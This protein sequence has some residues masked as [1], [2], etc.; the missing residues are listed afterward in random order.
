MRAI[1]IV[2]L[3]LALSTA[4]ASTSQFSPFYPALVR[5]EQIDAKLPYILREKR[6][7]TCPSNYNDCSNLGAPS[8]CCIS[9][10]DC[11]LDAARHVACCPKGS[12]CTGAINVGTQLASTTGGVVVVGTP[13]S[14]GGFIFPA[15]TTVQTSM[16]VTVAAAITTP[17]PISNQ[18]Y[19]FPAI[20]TSFANAA[21]C[22][23]AWSGCQNEYRKCT[24]QLAGRTDG[25]TISA[26]S[27]GITIVGAS[28]SVGGGVI[29]SVSICQ[30]LSQQAC[31]GLQIMNCPAY[32]GVAAAAT[33]YGPAVYGVGVG[34]ALGI[35]GQIIG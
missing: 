23:S 9:N 17:S 29:N 2:S 21:A 33:I 22:S 18:Y 30:T 1:G 5:L 32:N 34:F 16:Q 19:T 25:I 24:A 10:T 6:Q 31:Y 20:P 13:T 27:A 4:I 15:S 14:T 3:I 7:G 28:T 35:A 11:Q 12:V 26:P 8:A